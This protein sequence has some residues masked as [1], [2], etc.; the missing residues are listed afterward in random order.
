MKENK[1]YKIGE[2][3]IQNSHY[4]YINNKRRDC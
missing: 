1:R 2:K 4:G 3:I